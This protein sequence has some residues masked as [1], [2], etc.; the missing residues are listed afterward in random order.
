MSIITKSQCVE[1]NLAGSSKRHDVHAERQSTQVMD[2]HRGSHRHEKLAQEVKTRRSNLLMEVE[3]LI[4]S[5]TLTV[6]L[7]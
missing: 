6:A 7:V 2:S 1:R 3:I 5:F 4:E